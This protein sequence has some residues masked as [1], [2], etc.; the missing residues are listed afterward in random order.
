MTCQKTAV[1]SWPTSQKMVINAYS[2]KK[3]CLKQT[4]VTSNDE[5]W[6]N[7]YQVSLLNK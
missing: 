5:T 3:Q 4:A 2:K 6:N 7:F 1:T